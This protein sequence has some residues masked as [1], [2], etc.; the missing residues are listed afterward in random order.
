MGFSAR[1]RW[2]TVFGLAEAKGAHQDA[3]APRFS[4]GLWLAFTF[5]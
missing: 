1:L 3:G 2:R 5:P 4:I